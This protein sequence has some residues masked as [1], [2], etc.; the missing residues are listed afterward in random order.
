MNKKIDETKFVIKH[1]Q[2]LYQSDKWYICESTL[3]SYREVYKEIA[4]LGYLH[5]P[6]DLYKVYPS[7]KKI[8]IT[9][10]EF[11]KYCDNYKITIKYM[12]GSN[13]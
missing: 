10:Q 9:L 11:N 13:F 6:F 1:P 2:L 3:L 7:G 12:S 4:H 5:I 8:P